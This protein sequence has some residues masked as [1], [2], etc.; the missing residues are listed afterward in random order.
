MTDYVLVEMGTQQKRVNK[1]AKKLHNSALGR[2]D[3]HRDPAM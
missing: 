2:L 1:S 3:Q